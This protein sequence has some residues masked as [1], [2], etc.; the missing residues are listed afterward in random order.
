MMPLFQRTVLCVLLASS[1]AGLGQ[2]RSAQP[3]ASAPL[4]PIR[5]TVD[6]THAPEKILHAQLQ[7]PVTPNQGRVTVVYP[8]WIPGEHAA[9]GPIGDLT[10]V[11]FYANGQ[12]LTWS[13]ALVEM[14][15]FHVE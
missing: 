7:I 8:K 12:R 3:A 14:F 9:T 1:I 11:H 13:R 6:A 15:A 2:R 10:G 5:I 4:Q